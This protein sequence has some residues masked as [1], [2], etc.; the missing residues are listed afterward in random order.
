MCATKTHSPATVAAIGT[1]SGSRGFPRATAPPLRWRALPSGPM[2]PKRMN[3][4]EFF[5]K[6]SPLDAEQLR[7]AL[8]NL[9]WRGSAPLR[10]RRQVPGS[11]LRTR[12]RLLEGGI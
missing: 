9:Y 10:E 3:R 11:R 2:S 7:K 8:W 6:L 12:H 1:A 5:A 4:E